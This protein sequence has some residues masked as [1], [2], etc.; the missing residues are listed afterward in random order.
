MVN[1]AAVVTAVLVVAEHALRVCEVQVR[2]STLVHQLADT[3]VAFW[4]GCGGLF[5]GVLAQFLS[6]AHS[7]AGLVRAILE[8][9]CAVR[10]FVDGIRSTGMRVSDSD[11]RVGC[12]ALVL[13]GAPVFLDLAFRGVAAACYRFAGHATL[14]SCHAIPRGF[15][16]LWAL[17]ALAVPATL[18]GATQFLESAPVKVPKMASVEEDE[19]DEDDEDDDPPVSVDPVPAEP[20]LLADKQT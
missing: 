1:P 14:A 8:I 6:V 12:V 18:A 15:L 4:V 16:P 11:R 20:R 3:V 10:G 9:P 5:A 7:V 2:P 17:A 13:S 19:E